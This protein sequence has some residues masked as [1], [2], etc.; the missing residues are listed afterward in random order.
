M[1]ILQMLLFLLVGTAAAQGATGAG[2]RLP[3]VDT[4][5]KVE[6][7]PELGFN[8]PYYLRIPKGVNY[9]SVTYLLVETNNSGNNDTF[10]HHERETYKEII[11]NSLG[12]S[13]CEQLKV[14]FLMPV[15]PRPATEWQLYTHA[16]DKDVAHIKKGPMK[17]LDVQLIAMCAHARGVLQKIGISVTEK[18]LLNGFSASGSFANRF[19]AIHPDKVA[20]VACGGI[21]GIVILPAKTLNGK[22]LVYPIGTADFKQTFGKTFDAELYRNVPQ[23]IYMGALDDNDAVV[24][25]DAYSRAERTL[26]FEQLSQK[27]LPDRFAKCE[28]IYKQNKANALFKTYPNIGHRTDR[29]IFSEVCAFFKK[30]MKE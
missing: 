24:Y 2:E 27:M 16:F 11:K 26:V 17:R 25:D 30:V 8:F 20:A 4:V 29:L 6:A 22:K 18:I 15:F 12:S 10:A 14:P 23:F 19:T 1:K 28:D 5:I 21:N 3:N 9:A 7:H 13:L